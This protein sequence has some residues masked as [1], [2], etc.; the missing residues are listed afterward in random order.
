MSSYNRWVF[1]SLT[2]LPPPNIGISRFIFIL[3]LLLVVFVISSSIRTLWLLVCQPYLLASHIVMSLLAPLTFACIFSPFLP[4]QIL[5]PYLYF[6]IVEVDKRV[7]FSNQFSGCPLIQF[8]SDPNH[9]E[10]VSDPTGL[11]ARSH[12]TALTS[13]VS[14]KN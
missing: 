12:K 10:S 14:C 4:P 1:S 3:F 9:P 6:C 5:S 7:S 8:T 13:D 11:R 2:Q